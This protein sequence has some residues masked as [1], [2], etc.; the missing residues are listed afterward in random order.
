MSEFLGLTVN[1]H[2]MAMGLPVNEV[3]M[4]EGG[5]HALLNG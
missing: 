3:S 4:D 5:E 1:G 2:E